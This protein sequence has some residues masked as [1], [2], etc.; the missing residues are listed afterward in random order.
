MTRPAND[1]GSYRSRSSSKSHPRADDR[2][3][4]VGEPWS[5]TSVAEIRARLC[6]LQLERLEAESSG[7]VRCKPYM[8][9]LEAEWADQQEALRRAALEAV[10]A[11]RSELGNRQ[12]G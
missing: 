10:L 3:A 7:L 11:L 1:R 6:E 8:D 9:D 12:F 2:A 4:I 5:V